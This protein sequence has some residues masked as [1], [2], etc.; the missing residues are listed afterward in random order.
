[1]SKFKVCMLGAFAVGKTSLVQRYVHSIFS[2]KYQTTLGV[3]IDKKSLTLGSRTLEFML[4]DLAGEDEFIHVRSSYL[5]GSAGGVLV[6]DGTRP[7]TL[8]I[9][10]ELRDLLFE[11]V[12]EVPVVLMIN[13]S[14]LRN[15]WTLDD[16]RLRQMV[17][18][19]WQLIETSALDGGN[20]DK[21]FELLG[22]ELVAGTA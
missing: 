1:M 15:Q 20:V 22:R 3:K 11:E 7:E 13:K 9:V 21:A 14:D 10:F 16:K 5:R 4:W 17:A 12:G 6:A 2:E 19:G 8:D 18:D